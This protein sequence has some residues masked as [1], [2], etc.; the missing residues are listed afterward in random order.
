M[1]DLAGFLASLKAIG[2]DGPVT[3]EP[4]ADAIRALSPTRDEDRVLSRVSASLD[5][6]FDRAI[7][8]VGN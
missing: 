6:V 8:R 1:I 4:M 5:A 3:C 7:V 2:Y